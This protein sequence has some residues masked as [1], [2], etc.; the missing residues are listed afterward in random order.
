MSVNA[1]ILMPAIFFGHGSPMNAIEDNRYT[2]SWVEIEKSIPKPK[3]ILTISAHWESHDTKLTSNLKQKTIHD[4][5]GF[6]KELYDIQYNP[7]GD[8][9]LVKDVQGLIP[10]VKADESWGLDHGTWSVLRHLYPKADIPV[11]QLSID[12]NKS[13]KDHYEMA[14]KLRS[15]REKG[16]LIIGSGNIVH[17]LRM[18]N[19]NKVAKP[20]TWAID[21]NDSIKKAIQDK[22]HNKILDYKKLE[23]AKESVQ[24]PEHFIPL[25][26]I[27]ALRGDGDKISFFNDEIE[28][29]SLS[30]TSILIK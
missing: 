23:G 19:W 20:Y 9:K 5:Y 15:L 16:I 26:Y 25:I 7:N 30:M 27:L 21:F 4:F 10:E 11:L 22:N 24:T 13:P 12:K 17:N 29:G 8:A 3:A 28:M 2:K 14:K 1:L 6:P 18:I